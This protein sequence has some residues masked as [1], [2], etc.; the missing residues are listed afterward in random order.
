MRRPNDDPSRAA[1]WTVL[2]SSL[3]TLAFL[4]ASAIEENLTAEWRVYQQEFRRLLQSSA[5]DERQK[6]AAERFAVEI[7]QTTVPQLDLVDRCESCHVAAD[8]PASPIETEPFAAHPAQFLFVEPHPIERFGC[9]SCH[10]GQGRALTRADA[11]GRVEHWPSPILPRGSTAASCLKC[12][13]DAETLRGAEALAEGIELYRR[14]ACYGCHLT[15]G[16]EE[17]PPAGP[18][19]GNAGEKLNY[20]WLV[21]WLKDP[22]ELDAEAR[23]PNFGFD[24]GQAASV[25]DYLFSL[26]RRERVDAAARG[27]PDEAREAGRRLYDASGC[28]VCHRAGGGDGAFAEAYAPALNMIGAK[29]RSIEWITEWLADPRALHPNSTMPQFR[30]S[31]EQ[32][33]DLAAFLAAESVNPELEAHLLIEPE[34]IPPASIAEG[35]RLVETS[36]CVGCHDIPGLERGGEIAPDL[37]S[38]GARPLAELNFEWLDTERSR[39]AWLFKKVRTPRM[40]PDDPKMPYFGLSDEQAQRVAIFLLG[41]DG[42]TA[43]REYR[44]ETAKLDYE[45]GGRAAELFEQLKCLSCHAIKGRGARFA[46]DLTFEGSAVKRDWLRSYL[47]TPDRIRPLSKQMPNFRLSEREAEILTDYIVT[48]LRDTSI[49]VTE[50]EFAADAVEAGRRLYADKGCR[51]CHQM[52]QDGGAVG[53]D[54]TAV[55]DRLTS[56][57]LLERTKD[58][59]RFVPRIVEPRYGFSEEEAYALAA[60][61]ASRTGRP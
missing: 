5:G 14:S 28:S 1:K 32:R 54:L 42:R 44:V 29:V 20:T 36:G 55:G 12:H 43:P 37:S 39:A 35:K 40:F 2:L 45:P 59:H 22:R 16:F 17:L 9:T 25:A 56:G 21:K 23:M 7:R 46:P 30:F 11:H 8:W 26:T 3:A 33:L 58:A 27:F 51:A 49:Q 34:P 50:I 48:N 57:Y 52:D 18:P 6:Q 60:Y 41:L 10:Q 13:D 61:L 15:P 19:L 53:P 4:T 31:P 47:L 38:I 24:D